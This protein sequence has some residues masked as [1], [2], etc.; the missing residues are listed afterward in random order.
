MNQR[1]ARVLTVQMLVVAMVAVFAAGIISCGGE[2]NTLTKIEIIPADPS[3]ATG[4]SRQLLGTGF[5]SNGTTYTMTVLSWSSSD[6]AVAAISDSGLVTAGTATGTT[7]ITAVETDSNRDL[8]ATTTV[9]VEKIE[10][11]AVTPVKPGMALFTT[12]QFI[13]TATLASTVTATQDLT[14]SLTWGSSDTGI[15]T[16]ISSPG[17]LGSAIVS[18]GT[19]A[20]TTLITA[21]DL[22]STPT[23]SGTTELT[24][25]NT[26]LASVVIDP[27]DAS[28]ASGSS[29]KFTAAGTYV[30]GT[31]NDDLTSSMTWTTSDAGIATIAST[32]TVSGD[33]L[34]TAMTTTGTTGTVTITATDPITTRFG[35]TTLTVN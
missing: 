16:V 7:I 26:P 19:V 5:L 13:A 31:P 30:D 23:I 25:T 34:I 12:H 28:I 18:T 11:I 3:V 15:A 22:K 20:G 21:S 10:S 27:A 6:P 2:S 32:P 14:L 17:L 33:I 35:S 24:V 8:S 9:T 4:Y 29:R 1:G